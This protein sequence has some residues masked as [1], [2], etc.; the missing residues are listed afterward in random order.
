[1]AFVIAQFACYWTL[2]KLISISSPPTIASAATTKCDY[3]SVATNIV[4]A[5][6]SNDLYGTLKS[7]YSCDVSSFVP[8]RFG[9]GQR[10]YH[11]DSIV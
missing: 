1:M 11:L 10:M 6:D 5:L 3:I 8:I 2:H 4:L 9:S 7:R